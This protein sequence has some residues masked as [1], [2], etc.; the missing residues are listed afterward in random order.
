MVL[1]LF[2]RHISVSSFLSHTTVSVLLRPHLSV[3]GTVAKLHIGEN[4]CKEAALVG[5]GK[6]L[7]LVVVP[8]G[9]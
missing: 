1:E 3:S 4:K 5:F 9:V 6:A 7:E 2:S 8:L